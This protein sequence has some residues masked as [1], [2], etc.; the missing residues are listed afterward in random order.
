[1]TK[2]VCM[3]LCALVS[4]LL[5]ECALVRFS[6]VMLFCLFSKNEQLLESL[7][8]SHRK[9]RKDRSSKINIVIKINHLLLHFI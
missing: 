8:I 3:C 9:S 2:P 7:L 1:M 4:K 5:S 6:V